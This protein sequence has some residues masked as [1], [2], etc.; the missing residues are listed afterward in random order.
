MR[1]ENLTTLI[2]IT[3]G[4]DCLF[5]R[6]T[7]KG[8]MNLDKYLG[9]GGHFESDESPE[10]CVL[11][12]LYEEAGI[13]AGDL[14][15]FRYRGLVTFVSKQYDNEYMHVFTAQL[16]AERRDAGGHFLFGK[17]INTV[18]TVADGTAQSQDPDA[19]YLNDFSVGTEAAFR[20]LFFIPVVMIAADIDDGRVSETGEERQVF[21][22][23]VAGGQ[24]QIHA[25]ERFP[26][27]V[28]PKPFGRFVRNRQNPHHRTLTFCSS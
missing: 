24:D 20:R 28:P 27:K 4:N 8:D 15:D 2:Y 7:R 3:R 9:I 26:A 1:V 10:E 23:Q 25:A 21:R 19:A 18:R 22:G 17:H 5:I 6:K 11:R 12:E 16:P 14:T 13:K